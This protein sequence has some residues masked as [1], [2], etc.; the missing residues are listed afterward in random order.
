[1]IYQKE[2]A[3]YKISSTSPAYIVGANEVYLFNTRTRVIKYL[4]AS[5]RDGFTIKGTT[6]KDYD[7]DLSFKKTLR[8]PEEMIKSINKSTKLRALKALKALKTKQNATDG[9]INADTII[10]KINQ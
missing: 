7:A 8:K 5:K 10:L 9:R 2:C 6:V 1:V 4:V 3:E